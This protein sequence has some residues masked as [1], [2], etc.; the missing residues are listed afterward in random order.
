MAISISSR[1]EPAVE[2]VQWLEPAVAPRVPVILQRDILVFD[3]WLHNLDRT[4]G[5]PNLLW[6]S[7]RS[8]LVV[9][10]HN[11]AFDPVFTVGDFLAHHLFAGQRDKVFGDLAEQAR[12]AERLIAAVSVWDEACDNAPPEWWW[13]NDEH[14]VPTLFDLVAARA[15]VARCSTPDFWRMV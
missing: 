2:T 10:D 8:E 13:E 6:H 1:D 14:D 9:I 5:N 7:E 12:Y 4:L 15:L 11:Q 3:W